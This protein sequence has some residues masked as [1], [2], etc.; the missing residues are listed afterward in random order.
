MRLFVAVELDRALR[1]ALARAWE[2][3]RHLVRGAAS[4]VGEERIHL[5]LRFLGETPDPRIQDALEAAEAAAGTTRPFAFVMR[6]LGC[7][8]KPTLGRVFWAGIEPCPPLEALARRIEVELRGR[9]F[10]PEPRGFSPHVTL[11]RS[12]GPPVRL[13][14]ALD[15]RE[16]RF[17][18]QE[19]D[20][21]TLFESRLSPRGST[22]VPLARVALSDPG[23]AEAG[24]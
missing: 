9:G 18:E 22:Y 19:V 7:F 20:E 24:S 2:R 8:P 11:A 6:G 15:G 21:L 5:T 1:Q 23:P 13:E 10:P 12:K 4:S 17:G 3:S 16:P 14:A